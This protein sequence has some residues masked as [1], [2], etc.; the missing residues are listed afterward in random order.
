MKKI[1]ILLVAM[2]YVACKP[3]PKKEETPQ[4]VQTKTVETK[5]QYPEALSKV[6]GA[7]GGLKKW[8]QQRT[9]TYVLPKPENPETHTVDLW[10]RMDRIDSEK[11][12]MG[13]D[14]T[15][16]WLLDVDDSYEGDAAFYHNLMFY[17]Y[18]MPF[19]LADDGI[20][21]SETEDLVF[22]GK[23]YPGI[24]IGYKSGVGISSKDEYV[25]HYDPETHQ[26]A[27]LGYTVTYRTGEK[28]DNVKWIRYDDWQNL[29]GVVL[30]KSIT[31]YNY[32]GRNIL[33]PKSTVSFEEAT[34]S[35]TPKSNDFY[36]KPEGAELVTAK[37]S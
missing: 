32:E 27:W 20:V 9:L 26:M 4:A 2:A 29:N 10:S 1:A 5:P 14:G 8:K 24:H 15:E 37:K 16:I 12:T 21:Y 36:A 33:E 22:E 30:P 28:S 25:L 6:F 7:H 19:L 13:F 34:V 18:G 3:T 17:F 23:S 31:W 35:T 11:F